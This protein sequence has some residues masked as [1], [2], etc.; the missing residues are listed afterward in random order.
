MRDCHAIYNH[1][2]IG[3]TFFSY[4]FLLLLLTIFF[5]LEIIPNFFGENLSTN[6]T[7]AIH[8]HVVE[9]TN[10]IILNSY[11]LD[12]DKNSVK[13]LTDSKEIK[14][15]DQQYNEDE[16]KYS[17]TLEEYLQQNQQYELRISF[18]GI[19]NDK[20]QGFYKSQYYDSRNNQTA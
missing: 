3:I 17:F 15:I 14:V 5:R 13:L 2:I 9:S 12:I 6:G 4:N 10:K 1:Y 8:L 16:Q 7:V 11:Q 18:N 20:M 19:I